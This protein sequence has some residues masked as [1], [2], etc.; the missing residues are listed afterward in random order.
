VDELA[1]SNQQQ[2]SLYFSGFH[3]YLQVHVINDVYDAASAVA[4]PDQEPA[5][6][7]LAPDKRLDERHAWA[8]LVGAE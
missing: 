4:R 7:H 1:L 2:L 3:Y 6:K 8:A 5:G